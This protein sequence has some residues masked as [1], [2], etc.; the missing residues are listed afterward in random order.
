MRSTHGRCSSSVRLGSFSGR[1][2]VTANG[3]PRDE[4]HRL[5]GQLW[6]VTVLGQH[7]RVEDLDSVTFA[8]EQDLGFTYQ[9]W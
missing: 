3:G 7:P 6:L 9:V 1:A 2:R 5:L 8:L 4:G